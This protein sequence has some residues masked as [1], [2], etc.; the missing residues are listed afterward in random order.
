MPLWF[1]SF[2]IRLIL[3]FGGLSLAIGL[4]LFF[5]VHQ[6]SSS[7]MAEARGQVLGEL[8][9]HIASSL[10]ENLRE[11][12]RE[13][14]LLS[15][16]HTLVNGPLDSLEMRARLDQV[17]HAYR[18]YAWVGVSDNAGTIR[19][20]ADG[21]LI[22]VD[23]SQRPWFIEGRKGAFIG[24]IH[25]AV[26]LAKKLPALESGEPLR[27]IDFAIPIFDAQGRQRG[28]LATHAHWRWVSEVIETTLGDRPDTEGVEAFIFSAD[29]QLLHP[30]EQIGELALPAAL[31]D[32]QPGQ[33]LVLAWDGAR[34]YLTSARQ[35][36]SATATELG[37]RVV[38]R[39][40]VTTALAPVQRLKHSLILLGLLATLAFMFLA[41][42]LATSF[43]QPIEQLAEAAR[44]IAQGEEHR[45]FSY[46]G[47]ILELS[48]LAQSL[49]S[50]TATLLARR[51]ALAQSNLLLEQKV[52]ERTAELTDANRQLALLARRDALTGL[53]N[54][55]AANER[56]REEF[57][58]LK[59]NGQRYAALLMDVDHFKRVN[60][61]H[62]HEVGDAVLRQVADLL[63]QTLRQSDFLARFGGEEFL[64]LLPDC[65]EARALLVGEKI[66]AKV[67]DSPLP[68]VGTVTL[69]IGMALAQADDSD[70]DVALRRA[71]QA[72]YQ[73][74]SA[75]RNRVEC[76][77]EETA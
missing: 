21:L 29:G 18:H 13:L 58:R 56:L 60:D 77:A 9:E 17:K 10:A 3:F 22:G 30:Y 19:S 73:A 26:L 76:L 65:D 68:V 54:R 28:V 53:N 49:E 1:D 75:G 2:R 20:A 72:L 74:K 71:D 48:G 25:E 46:G 38:V 39:Q 41:Y 12:E 6:A 35:L 4:G 36:N 63:T 61:N 31:Q 40:P 50:M 66:R 45:H 43:S 44:R 23:A 67:A 64:V 33:P 27:F 70:E 5:Y 32:D 11:R 52:T 47:R 14:W 57:L 42:R 62:G 37:W 51:Q 34:E 55:L 59:R 16:S 8:T 7:S 15:Q 24:D 69:S